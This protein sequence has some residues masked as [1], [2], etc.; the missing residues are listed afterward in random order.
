M[1]PAHT[2]QTVQLFV[3]QTHAC[4]CT[5]LSAGRPPRHSSPESQVVTGIAILILPLSPSHDDM[6]KGDQDLALSLSVS[7]VRRSAV[8]PSQKR[9]ACS[10][11]QTDGIS[12]CL[13]RISAGLVLPR[14]KWNQMIPV[15]I[16]SWQ[17]WCAKALCRLWRQECGIITLLTTVLLSPNIHDEPSM[18]TPR[19]QKVFRR[20]MT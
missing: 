9:R 7:F 15:A 10:W 12:Q 11:G 1:T 4:V 8:S 18:G 14:M 5:S 20:S 16:A 13:L 3:L 6:A 17:R 19:Y 2:E